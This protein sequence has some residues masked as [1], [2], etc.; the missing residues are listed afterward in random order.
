VV[1][2]SRG[3]DSLYWCEGDPNPEK[4]PRH[5]LGRCKVYNDVLQIKGTILGGFE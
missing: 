1:V 4:L 5:T 2:A 3:E